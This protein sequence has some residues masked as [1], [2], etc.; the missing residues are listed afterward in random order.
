MQ[1]FYTTINEGTFSLCS[2][3]SKHISKVLRKRNGDKI[4][5]TNEKG[6]MIVAEIINSNSKKTEIRILEKKEQNKKHN[7][8][9]HIAISP[10]KNVDR[11]EWF[12]EKATE[13]GIDEI[14]PI[15]CDKSERKKIKLNRCE[16][17][18]QSAIKQSVKFHLPKI[19]SPINYKDFI[20]L[21]FNGNKYIAHCQMT[22]KYN[23]VN[24]KIISN[25]LILI[26]PEGDFTN[27]EITI[28]NERNF[29]SISLGVSRLRTETA[30]IVAV[31]II[32]IKN[33]K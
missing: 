7:Y 1:L 22:N 2:E 10:T 12:L 3:E 27:T 21:D 4:F 23:L 14:T 31:N 16:K 9:L 18:L 6:I 24:E 11:F 5:F 19:N 20:N 30:G 28:A 32:N 8:N 25:N 17:I 29:K 15:I 33:S 26:G 13:I